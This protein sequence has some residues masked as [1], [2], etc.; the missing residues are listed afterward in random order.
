MFNGPI[1]GVA[2]LGAI[3]GGTLVHLLAKPL[4]SETLLLFAA[5]SLLPAGLLSFVA[6]TWGGEP[7]PLPEEAGGRQGHLALRL[8]VRSRYLLL[9]A[10][11][12]AATQ[13]VSTVLDLRF[14]GLVDQAWPLK[15]QQDE[16]TAYLGRFQATVNAVASVLQFLVAPL[17]LRLV[18]LR[19]VHGSIPFLHLGASLALLL[20]P[21]LRTGA[22]AFLLFKAVDYSV[23]RAGKEIFYIPLSFDA[24][25]RAKEVIDAFGYRFA[26]G[27]TALAILLW[28]PLAGSTYPLL[29]MISASIWLG[30]ILRITRA[31]Q[32]RD[33]G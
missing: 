26:K 13:V 19:M 18:P 2:S 20:H 31:Y 25:Y 30:L 14:S 28:G 10:G 3:V 32:A 17:L 6:Y 29:A 27:G 12:I 15:E 9:L 11:V 5:A 21:S 16:Q 1:T 7:Q 8:L 22:A 23:F 4:G 24:R 33:E